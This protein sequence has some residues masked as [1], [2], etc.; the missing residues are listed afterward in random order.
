MG[1]AIQSVYA[2]V[3]WHNVQGYIEPSFHAN[4][5]NHLPNALLRIQQ[6]VAALL[7]RTTFGTVRYRVTLRLYHGWHRGREA[8]PARR[9]FEALASD[10]S[11]ARRF[12]SVSFTRGFQFGN[13]LVCLTNSFPLYSTYRGGG[14]GAGQKMVDSAI[15][16]DL[17]HLFHFK[18]ADIC[19]IVSDDDDY[20]PALLTAK[21]WSAKAMLLRKPASGVGHTTDI[22]CRGEIAYWSNE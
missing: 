19:I 20:V 3:D 7:Q 2:L 11:L 14:Q 9:D 5:R 4:P 18:I 1:A 16:C 13:E 10:Q 6:E 22:D 8:T 17:L 12:S 15:V 21:A